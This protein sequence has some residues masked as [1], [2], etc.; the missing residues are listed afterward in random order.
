M[1]GK[2]NAK[3]WREAN[4]EHRRQYQRQWYE[5]NLAHVLSY[6][7]SYTKANAERA[8]EYVRQRRARKKMA[9]GAGFVDEKD[10]LDALTTGWGGLCAYCEKTGTTWDHIVPLTKGGSNLPENLAPA[11][12]SCNSSKGAKLLADWRGG[13]HAETVPAHA[14]AVAAILAG[15]R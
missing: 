5:D 14:A 2:Q 12:K 15:R 7:A 4:A 13:I 9:A 3:A 1:K 11:C 6:N 10:R 8:C